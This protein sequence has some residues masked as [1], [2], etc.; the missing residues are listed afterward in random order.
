MLYYTVVLLHYT[1]IPHH[2][3]PHHTTPHRTTPH[4]TAAV[5]DDFLAYFATEVRAF[6]AS[7]AVGKTNFL[8]LGEVAAPADWEARALGGMES[9]PVDPD[10]HGA[11]PKALTARMKDVQAT[12]LHGPGSASFPL[13]G[14]NAVY[15]FAHSGT[16]R[17]ALLGNKS[18]SAVAKYFDSGAWYLTARCLNLPSALSR[19]Q[20]KNHLQADIIRYYV[21]ASFYRDL[22]DRRGVPHAC[23]A[24]C[25]REDVLDDA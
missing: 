1:T 13:P 19:Y 10:Q 9:D 7:P 16:A 5:T 24:A 25:G 8:V 18:P 4:R 14:L 3:T 21:Y 23:R 11:V 17:D 20:N 15:E 12:Y 2:T 6:A 22:C